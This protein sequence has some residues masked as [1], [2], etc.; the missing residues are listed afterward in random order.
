MLGLAAALP[1]RASSQRERPW[2]AA[3]QLDANLPDGRFGLGNAARAR[4]DFAAA[5]GQ[6]S[7]L[8]RLTPHCAPGLAPLAA[9]QFELGHRDATATTAREALRRDPANPA[10][11]APLARLRR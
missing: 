10:A 5:L 4:R 7:T 6:L 1:E 11:L 9:A 3:R 8:R 2:S